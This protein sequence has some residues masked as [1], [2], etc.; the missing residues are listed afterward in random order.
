MLEDFLPIRT[1]KSSRPV[2]A[3]CCLC[4]LGKGLSPSG[5]LP[6]QQGCW[7]LPC[8]VLGRTQ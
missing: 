1:S 7:C 5:A 3:F 8:S 4:D 2:S 6:T